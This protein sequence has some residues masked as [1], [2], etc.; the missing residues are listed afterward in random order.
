VEFQD[1]TLFLAHLSLGYGARKIQIGEVADRCR[2][3]KKPVILAGDG[4]IYAGE[5]ELR[6]LFRKGL[7]R[8]ANDGNVPTYPSRLPALAL[9]FVLY[10]E[11][12]DMKKFR[13]PQ[14]RYSDHLPLVC[15][16]TPEGRGRE[17]LAS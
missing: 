3:A 11:G 10:S 15:D 1:F 2:Q 17:A 6:P 8:N 12:I 13:V 4:N 14:V 9:D 5:K 16:F 7:F